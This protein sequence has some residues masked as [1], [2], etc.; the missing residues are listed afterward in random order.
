MRPEQRQN[1]CQ[2]ETPKG[3]CPFLYTWNGERFVFA[4]DLCWAAPLGMQT[5]QGGIMPGR[6]WEYLLVPG[7]LLA[8]RDGRYVLQCTGELWEAEYF[9]QVELMVLDHPDEFEVYSNEK[10]GPPEITEFKIHTARTRHYPL[11]AHV[12][13]G[14]D[15]LAGIAQ[16]DGVYARPFE[17]KHMQ[18]YT[19]DSLLELDLGS[20]PDPANVKLFLTGWMFPTDTSINV[21]LAEN[22][23]LPGP[24]A[25]SVWVPD[26]DGEWQQVIP[27]MGFPGG[28]TKTIVVDLSGKFLSGDHRVRIATSMEIYW[29]EIFFTSGEE[30]GEYSLTPLTAV[31]ADLHFRG[32]SRRIPQPHHAP[33]VFDYDDVRTEPAWAPMQGCFTRFGDVT[34]LIT[35]EDDRMVILYAGDEMTVEFVAPP[36]P[37]VGW[38]RDFLLHNVGWDKDADLNTVLGQTVEPL[39]FAAMS[40]YPYPAAEHYPDTPLHREYL[41]KYQTRTIDDAPFR[42]LIHAWRPGTELVNP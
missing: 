11:A 42:R 18:G 32:F 41:Q 3:S 13:S 40:R 34:E 31:A 30:A 12:A 23:L 27:S 36:P 16:R 22:P 2:V 15:V 25:P 28:K 19:E 38:K 39:P 9:D 24:Q 5:A 21:A 35:T 6:S 33:P 37:P 26:E 8:P 14:R 20:V 1:V 17:T 7:E 10:V 4:T 29:D